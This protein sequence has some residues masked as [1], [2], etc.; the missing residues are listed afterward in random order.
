MVY[1]F[2]NVAVFKEESVAEYVIVYSPIVLES[3]VPEYVQ[4]TGPSTLSV[5]VQPKLTLSPIEYT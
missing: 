2:T 4:A 1:I 5:A 3:T